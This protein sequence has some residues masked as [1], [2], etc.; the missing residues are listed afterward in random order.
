MILEDGT[1]TGYKG[2][3]DK[4]FQLH[5]LAETETIIQDA[6]V[7]GNAYNIN[8]GYIDLTSTGGASG[9]DS[10]IL[11]FKNNESPV[12]GESSIFIDS[13]IVGINNGGTHSKTP[14]MTVIKAPTAGTII[15]GASAVSVNSN[16]NFGNSGE[17]ASLV[18]KGADANTLTGGTTF[19]PAFLTVNSRSVIA[20][21]TLLK[22][23]STMGI[24]INPYLSSGTARVYIALVLHRV[25]GNNQL[26]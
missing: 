15:S 16:R 20:I 22:K 25:D 7:K 9:T 14:E 4:N 23:G 10:A 11:Y 3:V 5:V 13:I 18:Y 19:L 12:N 26:G 2:G 17:L 8:T 1:G 6:V 21:D 24:K